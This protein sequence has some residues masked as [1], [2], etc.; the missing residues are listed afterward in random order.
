MT[1]NRV[2]KAGRVQIRGRMIAV[3]PKHAGCRQGGKHCRLMKLLSAKRQAE[4]NLATA[5]EELRNARDLDTETMEY[6]TILAEGHRRS[7]LLG[8]IL[9]IDEKC[10][11]EGLT[12]ILADMAPSSRD[13][14]AQELSPFASGRR[15]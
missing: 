8:A 5:R 3:P 12:E 7:A 13:M 4:T 15:A 10:C 14:V 11:C 9:A 6:Q 2:E 1:N